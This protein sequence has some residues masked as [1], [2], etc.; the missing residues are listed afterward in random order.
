MPTQESVES[1]KD[2][3][4][5]VELVRP[6]DIRA[7]DAASGAIRWQEA[8]NGTAG[9]NAPIG[10]V[11]AGFKRLFDLVASSAALVVFTPLLLLISILI[12]LDSTGPTLFYQQRRG[13][14]GALIDVYKFRTMYQ[15]YSTP[16]P[17]SRSFRQTRKDDPRVTRLGSFL[18][19]TSLDELPQLFNVV[20]GSM[21]LVGPRPHPAPLDERFRHLIPALDSRYEVKPGLTGW[22]QIHG[23]RGE[24]TRLED[25]IGR[26][27]HDRHYIRHWSFFLDVKIIAITIVKGWTHRNAY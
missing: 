21:S 24:T 23:F 25:M 14:H 22:A 4:V 13:R 2:G 10:G 3:E 1:V 27:E 12:K 15:D 9:P 18:R 16:V 17:T 7:P 11:D 26:V 20:Q 5:T 8:A 19:R 6:K